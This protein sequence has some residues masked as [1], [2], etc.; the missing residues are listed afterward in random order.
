MGYVLVS[1]AAFATLAIFG[2]LAADD[3]LRSNTL[4]QWRFG[5]AAAVLATFGAFRS[6]LPR[7]TRVLLLGSGLVY[8]TQTSFYFAALHRISAGTTALLLYLAPAFVILYAAVLGTRPNRLQIV[9]V[10]VALAGLGVILGAPSG[11]DASSA[12]LA[13]GAA[14]GATLAGYMLLG[15]MAFEGVPPLSIAAHSMVGAVVGFTL[16]DL[17]TQRRLDLPSGAGQWIIVAAVV[18]V[19]TLIAIPLLFAGIQA[20]GAAPTAVISTAEPAFTLVF[21]AALLDEPMRAVQLVGGGLILAA[22]V[23]AQRSANH[24]IATRFPIGPTD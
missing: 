1:A 23:T 5:V 21:A 17:A 8:T 22:A 13:F 6:T 18:I 7:H 15:E 9:G 14:A 10:G 4:L 11:A 3:G 24:H 16:L 12:G 19:P 20:I 2:R